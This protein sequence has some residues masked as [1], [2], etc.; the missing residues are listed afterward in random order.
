MKKN[1]KLA[2]RKKN[3]YFFKLKGKNGSQKKKT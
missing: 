2:T 1:W 3:Y